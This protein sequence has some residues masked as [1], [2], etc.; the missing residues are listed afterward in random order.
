MP[1]WTQSNSF[2]GLFGLFMSK[3]TF[4]DISVREN[5]I[6]PAFDKTFQWI[7][8]RLQSSSKPW[9]SFVDW[10]LSPQHVYW[11]TGKAGS[12]KSTLMK[13]IIHNQRTQ[14]LLRIWANNAGGKQLVTVSF[15]L[16]NAGSQFQRTQEGLLRSLLYKALEMYRKVASENLLLHWNNIFMSWRT[17]DHWTYTELEQAFHLLLAD[18]DCNF[19]LFIDGLDGRPWMIFEDEFATKPQLILQHLTHPDIAHYINSTLGS[20]IAFKEICAL[21]G[22][23]RFAGEIVEKIANKSSGVFLWV[24][25]AVRSLMAGLHD[26]DGAWELEKRLDTLPPELED[27][28]R[29]ILHIFESHYFSDAA[30][31]FEINLASTTPPTLLLMSFAIEDPSVA[32]RAGVHLLDQRLRLFRAI[33]MRRRLNSRCKGLLEVGIE[34]KSILLRPSPT[35]PHVSDKDQNWRFGAYIRDALLDMSNVDPAK[36]SDFANARIEYLHR[37]VRE[38]LKRKDVRDQLQAATPSEWNPHS[39]LA[40]AHLLQL[41]WVY[42]M[43]DIRAQPKALSSM[44]KILL[45]SVRAEQLGE[46]QASLMEALENTV[47][48]NLVNYQGLRIVETIAAQSMGREPLEHS[49]VNFAGSEFLHL[50]IRCGPQAYL[51][52]RICTIS[53]SGTIRG[54]LETATEEYEEGYYRF[55]DGIVL[56]RH[57]PDPGLVE[58]LLNQGRLILLAENPQQPFTRQKDLEVLEDEDDNEHIMVTVPTEKRVV[59]PSLTFPRPLVPCPASTLAEPSIQEEEEMSLDANAIISNEFDSRHTTDTLRHIQNSPL[60]TQR[61]GTAGSGATRVSPGGIRSNF[62][63]LFRKKARQNRATG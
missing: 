21:T 3:L 22:D 39:A 12:G 2:D 51:R 31:L 20:S 17:A 44:F 54:L 8:Q 25:L 41:K 14:D 29:R 27:L 18:T 48:N 63:N 26:G 28:F 23:G 10:L 32:W 15:Y 33:N 60:D 19:C 11:I 13:Y 56:H 45:H 55:P 4:K 53:D 36:L 38:F 24:V 6:D 58:A 47:N 43:R 61:A 62:R 5:R 40:R 52:D 59:E 50:I 7:F 46:F 42:H 37:T 57:K 49:G 34:P 16:W 30:V 35:D 9:S 1:S